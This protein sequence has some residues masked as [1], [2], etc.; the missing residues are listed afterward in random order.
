MLAV[1]W[2]VP[3][4]PGAGSC[5]CAGAPKGPALLLP[6]STPP[7]TGTPPGC[8]GGRLAVRTAGGGEGTGEGSTKPPLSTRGR[9]TTTNC[10]RPPL[11]PLPVLLATRE[12]A[13]GVPVVPVPAAVGSC[14]ANAARLGCDTAPGK[15]LVR[16]CR[17]SILCWSSASSFRNAFLQ[18][19]QGGKEPN[20]LST[21]CSPCSMLQQQLT[22]VCKLHKPNRWDSNHM[23]LYG[24]LCRQ[25]ASSS[26]E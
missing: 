11:P 24:Q 15:L 9:S 7:P 2:P 8:T 13:V 16:A 5:C 14:A 21:C 25:A 12:P 18:D 6:D 19:M 3:E 4:G 20:R 26:T 1:G 17:M 22:R 10:S 23:V